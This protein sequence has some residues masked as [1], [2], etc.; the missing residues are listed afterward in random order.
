MIIKLVINSN[1]HKV[2]EKPATYKE[3]LEALNRSF[4]D[5][6]PASYDIKYMDFEEDMIIIEDD[7]GFKLAYDSYIADKMN[8]L[9]IYI[10]PSKQ[11]TSGKLNIVIM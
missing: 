2:K 3:L 6:L 9:K 7:E 8:S 10:I 4:K 1:I 11:E 5:K